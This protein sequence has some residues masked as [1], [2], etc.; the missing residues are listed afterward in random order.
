VPKLHT[1]A[2]VRGPGEERDEPVVTD[3]GVAVDVLEGG[4]WRT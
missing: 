4:P 3:D 1:D 2:L